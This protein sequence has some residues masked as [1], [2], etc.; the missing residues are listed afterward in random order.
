MQPTSPPT[1]PLPYIF[2]LN[3]LKVLVRVYKIKTDLLFSYRENKDIF[4]KDKD[5]DE[6]S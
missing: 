5:L 1:I 6:V 4:R 3:S 2:I